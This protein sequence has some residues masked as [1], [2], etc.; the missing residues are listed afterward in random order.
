MGVG[1]RAL[2]W[3]LL[4]GGH[5]TTHLGVVQHGDQRAAA[6]DV[7]KQDGNHVVNEIE[8]KAA[9]ARE[10]QVEYLD[11]ARDDVG[12]VA[13]RHDVGDQQDHDQLRRGGARQQPD[14][15]PDQPVG[16]HG[17]GEQH[18]EAAGGG[19]LADRDEVVVQ[20]RVEDRH[21]GRERGEQAG[22]DQIGEQHDAPQPRQCQ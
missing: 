14:H 10:H 15:Q 13:E 12:E 17:L 4:R 2:R 6:D 7:A 8:G 20:V 19:R 22:A 21:A 16:Q 1:L 11:R 3:A 9:I 5:L 18:D